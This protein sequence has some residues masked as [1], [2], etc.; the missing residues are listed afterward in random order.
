MN[1][2]CLLTVLMLC[3]CTLVILRGEASSLTTIQAPF[4][5]ISLTIA[6]GLSCKWLRHESV[7]QAAGCMT[8]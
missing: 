5:L 1:V 8:V 7:Q 6:E 4:S 2:S 3:T